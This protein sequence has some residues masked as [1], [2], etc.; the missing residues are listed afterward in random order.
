MSA[1]TSVVRTRFQF[2]PGHDRRLALQPREIEID[3]AVNAT[4]VRIGGHSVR[5]PYCD[6]GKIT[7][8]TRSYVEQYT[9]SFL[10]I[11]VSTGVEVR[12][13]DEGRTLQCGSGSAQL[14]HR[15]CR[16]RNLSSCISTTATLRGDVDT[17]DE[18]ANTAPIVMARVHR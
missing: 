9:T 10:L 18:K 14:G 17:V 7:Q 15:P 5:N 11:C 16:L 2:T 8:G 12:V 6:V 13:E 1:D 4:I 3:V